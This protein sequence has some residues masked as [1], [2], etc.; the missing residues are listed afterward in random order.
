MENTNNLVA[1]LIVAAIAVSLAGTITTL[2][3]VNRY[4]GPSLTGAATG[5]VNVTV[6]ESIALVFVNQQV[7]FPALNPQGSGLTFNDDTTDNDPEPLV[8][9]NDGSTTVNITLDSDKD[10][11]Q[12]QSSPSAYFTFMCGDNTSTCDID[13]CAD[14]SV[15]TFTNVPQGSPDLVIWNMSYRENQDQLEIEFNVTVPTGEPAITEQNVS[16]SLVATTACPG[17]PDCAS[18]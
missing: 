5:Y 14:C 11:W 3:M 9:R 4:L 2:N 15:T 12:T 16:I 7:D 17:D 18:V 6:N 8:I 10:I 13:E 1:V